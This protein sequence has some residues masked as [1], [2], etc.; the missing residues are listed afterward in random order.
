MGRKKRAYVKFETKVGEGEGR[1][2]F[3][4]SDVVRRREVS[5]REYIK[6]ISLLERGKTLDEIIRSM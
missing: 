4:C 3:I 5:Y 2:Y 6:I 1:Q